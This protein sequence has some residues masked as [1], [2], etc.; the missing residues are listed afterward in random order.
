MS[1]MRV[2]IKEARQK[3]SELVNTV[4]LKRERV[5]ITSRNKPKAVLVSI[6]DAETLQEGSSRKARRRIQLESLRRLRGSLAKKGVVS[7]SVTTLQ[8]LR[9]ERLGE[10]SNGN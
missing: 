3:F 7:D 6:Q 1:T 5:V 8:R 9:K 4:A 10:L 2:N